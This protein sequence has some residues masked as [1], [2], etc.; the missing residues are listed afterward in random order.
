V[1]GIWPKEGNFKDKNKKKPDWALGAKEGEGGAK[2]PSEGAPSEVE[3]G[4]PAEAAA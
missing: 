3:G 1:E 2:A 4:E